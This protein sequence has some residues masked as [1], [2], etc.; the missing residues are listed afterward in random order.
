MFLQV[1]DDN[2]IATAGSKGVCV[3]LCAAGSKDDTLEVWLT[4]KARL[5]VDVTIIVIKV[6]PGGC[7]ICK[8]MQWPNRPDEPFEPTLL[9]FGMNGLQMGGLAGKAA[10]SSQSMLSTWYRDIWTQG[11]RAN[12]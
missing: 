2:V 7:R 5:S 8:L 10:L 6:K 1:A 9:A 4:N 12:D 3:L 11:L